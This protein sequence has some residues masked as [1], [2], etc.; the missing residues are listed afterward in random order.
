MKMREE[1]GSYLSLHCPSKCL[2]EKKKIRPM[3]GT[4]AVLS[5]FRITVSYSPEIANHCFL[6]YTSENKK[7]HPTSSTAEITSCSLHVTVFRLC[8]HMSA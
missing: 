6:S 4:V 1:N 5:P 2:L 8:L 7:K 3:Q